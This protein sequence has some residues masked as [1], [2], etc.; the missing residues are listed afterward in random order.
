MKS[1]NLCTFDKL[2][3][4]E[5]PLIF[6]LCLRHRSSITKILIKLQWGLCDLLL[7]SYNILAL[8]TYCGSIT[9]YHR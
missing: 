7:M 1:S 4:L 5:D 9:D 3:D 6:F 2:V 8:V